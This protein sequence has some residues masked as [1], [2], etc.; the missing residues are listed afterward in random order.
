MLSNLLQNLWG[1]FQLIVIDEAHG[2]V[3]SQY[4]KLLSLFPSARIVGLTATPFRLNKKESLGQVFKASIKG[5]SISELIKRKVI[6]SELCMNR[7]V[8]LVQFLVRPVVF[9]P[10]TAPH[11]ILST[12]GSYNTMHNTQLIATQLPNTKIPSSQQWSN[13]RS[14][15][16]D[17]GLQ[18]S[19]LH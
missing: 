13:G 19:V 1:D 6:C 15:V 18:L 4:T 2:A 17:C 11:S 3:A 8:Y 10:S 16:R 9:A 5:P 14:I 12:K 7:L